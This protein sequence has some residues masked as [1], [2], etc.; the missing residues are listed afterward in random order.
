VAL[1]ACGSYAYWRIED[2]HTQTIQIRRWKPG[3]SDVEIAYKVS[4]PDYVS[5]AYQIVFG[6]CADDI[7]TLLSFTLDNPNISTFQM[8]ALTT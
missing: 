6:G 7:L 4:A 2:R 5:A 1:T 8:L 3:M